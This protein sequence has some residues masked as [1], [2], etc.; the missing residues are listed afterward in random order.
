MVNSFPNHT[1]HMCSK[2]FTVPSS[3]YAKYDAA[4]LF[5]LLLCLNYAKSSVTVIMVNTNASLPF[6]RVLLMAAEKYN[7]HLRLIPSIN[8]A[9]ILFNDHNHGEVVSPSQGSNILYLV[10]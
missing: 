10:L 1:Q 3:F 7:S 4:C 5:F 6:C 8:C 9:G 2:T